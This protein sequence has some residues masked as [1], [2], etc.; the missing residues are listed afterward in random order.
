MKKFA[1]ILVAIL[2][3]GGYFGYSKFM[4]GGPTEPPAAAQARAKTEQKAEKKE[5]LKEPIDG[6]I[7]EF[8]TEFVVTLPG[9]ERHFAKFSVALKVDDKTPLAVA[10][11]HGGGAALPMHEEP[12]AR[13]LIIR[14]VSSKTVDDLLDAEKR[15]ELKDEIKTE[16]N[17]DL[18]ETVVLE[19]FF[20]DF[21]VQ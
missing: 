14:L 2:L 3:V 11:G 13:D 7:D 8:V 1:P 20:T 17:K 10:S 16:I 4:G 15:E 18:P 6:P 12:E 5:R 19:V 9:V 21:A